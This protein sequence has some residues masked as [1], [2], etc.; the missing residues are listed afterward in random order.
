[1]T[2]QT[3]ASQGRPHANRR[4]QAVRAHQATHKNRTRFL[5][6]C[7]Y[8]R[9]PCPHQTRIAIICDK[10][11]PHLT[12]RKDNRA[13]EQAAANNAEIACTPTN[14]SWLTPF[15]ALRYLALDGTNHASHREQ[16]SIIRR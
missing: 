6:F 1:M 4:G 13:W 9:S 7:R 8:L 3:A 11:R 2:G 5:E 10:Y 16:A 14:S 12:T 15:T